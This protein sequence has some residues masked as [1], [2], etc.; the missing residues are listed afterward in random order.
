MK[1]NF[2]NWVSKQRIELIFYLPKLNFLLL[3]IPIL[4]CI[5][6]LFQEQKDSM[7][8]ILLFYHFSGF[9]SII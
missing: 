5:Y 8:I 9:S 6:Q 7:I 4:W 2:Q 3:M 1:N